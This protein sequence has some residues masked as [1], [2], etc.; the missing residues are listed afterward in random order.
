[1]G[2]THGKPSGHANDML[3]HR[4]SSARWLDVAEVPLAQLRDTIEELSVEHED[5]STGFLAEFAMLEKRSAA[6]LARDA[7]KE[8]KKAVNV[9]LNRYNDVW[10][11]DRHRVVISQNEEGTDCKWLA[12]SGVC[13]FLAHHKC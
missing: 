5:G 6:L 12:R 7:H 3:V 9:M 11:N 2:L 8:A 1:M 13:K 10:P 4:P